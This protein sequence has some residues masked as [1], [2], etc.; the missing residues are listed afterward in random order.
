MN[1]VTALEGGVFEHCDVICGKPVE[2]KA[3]EVV[4][5]LTARKPSNKY[6]VLYVLIAV[7]NLF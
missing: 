1:D 6:F 4:L 7:P 5:L 2:E 3:N